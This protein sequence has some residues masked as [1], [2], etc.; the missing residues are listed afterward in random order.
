MKTQFGK[1]SRHVAHDDGVKRA[2]DGYAKLPEASAAGVLR[3]QFAETRVG[4]AD[5]DADGK[6]EPAH[7]FVEQIKIRMGNDTSAL[8]AA[9]ENAAGAVLGAKF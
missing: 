9:H 5:V 7:L 4:V 3:Y 1:K 8:D 6:V 2:G